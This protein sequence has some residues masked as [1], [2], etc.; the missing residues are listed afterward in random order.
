MANLTLCTEKPKTNFSRIWGSLKATTPLCP[1][2]SWQPLAPPRASSSLPTRRLWLS[3]A[4]LV[5]C[6]LKFC[7]FWEESSQRERIAWFSGFLGSRGCFCFC[8]C[9]WKRLFEQWIEKSE[10]RLSSSLHTPLQRLR[11]MVEHCES[12]GLCEAGRELSVKWRM[13][14]PGDSVFRYFLSGFL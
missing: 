4:S 13:S 5:C 8:L 1:P 9:V 7:R 3:P 12:D 11:G 2:A 10:I 6:V 14:C